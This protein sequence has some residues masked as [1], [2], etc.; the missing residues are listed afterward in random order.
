MQTVEFVV[1]NDRLSEM[2]KNIRKQENVCQQIMIVEVL[3]GL[4]IE[5]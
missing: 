1:P 3:H 4:H 5:F 2:V